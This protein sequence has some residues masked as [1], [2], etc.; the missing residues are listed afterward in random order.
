MTV[1]ELVTL[2]QL[3]NGQPL[4]IEDG[5]RH[6]LGGLLAR[7]YVEVPE[8]HL[9]LRNGESAK[10]TDKGVLHLERVLWVLSCL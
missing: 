4:K 3:L 8:R 6:A 7:D 2:R 5:N 9:G 1:P 10:I